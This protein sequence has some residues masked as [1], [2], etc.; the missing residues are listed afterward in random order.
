MTHGK[1]EAMAWKAAT[2]KARV[3]LDCLSRM[4]TLP[5]LTDVISFRQS[6]RPSAER[7]RTDNWRGM[8]AT[9]RRKGN[10]PG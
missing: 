2:A 10:K 5:V 8:L 3:A 9:V 7:D 1:F 4:L 6:V